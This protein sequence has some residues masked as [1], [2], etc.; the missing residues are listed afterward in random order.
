MPSQKNV[1]QL[2]SINDKMQ[3]AKNVIFT[4]YPGLDVATQTEM[5][6]K[7][8]EAGGEILVQKNNLLR[9]AVK[10]KLNDLPQDVDEALNGPTAVV[11]G[12]EDA[13]SATKAIVE[14]QKDHEQLLIKVGLLMGEEGQTNQVLSEAQIKDLAKLPGRQELL[15]TLVN[16][17]NSPI[18]GF[19]N[20]LSGNLRGLVTVLS[21]IKDQKAA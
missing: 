12:Y 15:A 10:N 2:Q 3:S 13:V 14:F 21:A 16:R 5:R 17:L 7:V 9:L 6:A 20:V 19:A 4:A 1:D 18:Q 8:K 11:Y